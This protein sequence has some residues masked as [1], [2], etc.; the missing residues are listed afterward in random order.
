MLLPVRA[1]QN[2]APAQ[3]GQ[4]LATP[5]GQ[6]PA[7]PGSPVPAVGATRDPN[8]AVVEK[9]SAL[10]HATRP[11]M[12]D[13]LTR[14]INAIGR[15]ISLPR[16]DGEG[17]LGYALRLVEGLKQA[18]PAQR[19]AVEKLL[20][21]LAPGVD[22]KL[23][24]EALKN[25]TGQAA[26][27]IVALIEAARTSSLEL[28]IRTVVASY[29]QD[30]GQSQGQANAPKPIPQPNVLAEAQRGNSAPTPARLSPG[31][32]SA[33]AQDAP[34]L[35][36]PVP[37]LKGGMVPVLSRP[38][39]VIPN[40][41]AATKGEV[42]MQAVQQL[43]DRAK[44][45]DGSGGETVRRGIRVFQS[46]LQ[47]LQTI[48]KAVLPGNR[49]GLAAT[50]SLR[51]IVA[52]QSAAIGKALIAAGEAA[53]SR[54][55]VGSPQGSPLLAGALPQNASMAPGR[56]AAHDPV[57]VVLKAFGHGAGAAVAQAADALKAVVGEAQIAAIRSMKASR[58][59]PFAAGGVQQTEL[60]TPLVPVPAREAGRLPSGGNAAGLP[61]AFD[62]TETALASKVSEGS[63][64]LSK[65][66][67]AAQERPASAD[68][69]IA[70]REG[71][72]FALVGYL[73]AQEILE[74]EKP[75]EVHRDSEDEPA[76]EGSPEEQDS[77]EPEDGEGE[78]DQDDHGS[79]APSNVDLDADGA[80][81]DDE[82]FDY[83]YGLHRR[84]QM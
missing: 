10:I 33:R 57:S 15:A 17:D 18:T 70:L 72:P 51:T 56:G 25:P 62:A 52:N 78:P 74:V 31:S 35:Q 59:V 1:I 19:T 5:A 20:R 77:A 13:D 73:P 16:Q 49:E 9:L 21:Q 37:S 67:M 30:T 41:A 3:P 23:V 71:I 42:V 7:A 22:L 4:Q 12:T 84:N 45:A 29:R 76:D 32:M 82:L 53:G 54:Q 79:Q 2:A 65:E 58:P 14:L 11:G 44:P 48:A 64:Q 6:L 40:G 8:A 24:V 80:D 69:R 81:T 68:L 66:T 75:E 26:A 55:S 43:A 38:E 83:G 46:D 47:T 34:G 27:R 60:Y 50:G 63:V 28:A 39:S 61:D 36:I